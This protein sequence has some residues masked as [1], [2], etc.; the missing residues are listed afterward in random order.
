MANEAPSVLDGVNRLTQLAGRNRLEL[1]MFSLAGKQ[2]YGINVFKVREVIRCPSLTKVP[3]S[4]PGV[5]G[6]ATIRGHTISVLDLSAMIGCESL[7]DS[8]DRF[9]VVAEY[10][11]HTVGFLVGD[12][13]SIV[14]KNWEEIKPPPEA[15]SASGYLTAVTTIGDELIEILD[16][17]QVLGDL[18]GAADERRFAEVELDDFTASDIEVF[19]ADDS[20]VARKQLTRT[21]DEMGIRYRL[22][23]NGREALEMLKT[24]ADESEV[25]LAQRL[26]VVISDIEMPEMDGYALTCEIRNDERLKNLYVC[27]HT[28]LSGSF[29]KAMAERVG[30]DTLIPKFDPAEL[31]GLVRGR[32][33]SRADS[34]AA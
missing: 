16:V 13:H 23:T 12:V 30:A 32:L 14:N 33:E 20:S 31:A 22:A 18:V 11:R 19:I 24:M 25:P 7:A 9:V 8:A 17:E 21:M 34:I 29:N 10:N 26:P 27:L 6:L 3:D 2:R 1:L 4:K 28:S 15:L 5:C